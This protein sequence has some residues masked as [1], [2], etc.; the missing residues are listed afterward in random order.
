MSSDSLIAMSQVAKIL[1]LDFGRNILYRKLRE[2]GILFKSTNEPKQV[3]VNKGYF[4]LKETTYTNGEGQMKVSMQT[5]V[6]QKGLGYI[7]K[8]FQIITLPVNTQTKPQI[9]A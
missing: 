4:K 5:F 9:S 6:T 8:L 1:G 3:F 2:K 7:A